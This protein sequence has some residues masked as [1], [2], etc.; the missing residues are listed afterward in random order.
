MIIFSVD[1]ELARRKAFSSRPIMRP[2][3][4]SATEA[5]LRSDLE[6]PRLPRWD[7]FIKVRINE[8][9]VPASKTNSN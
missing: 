4:A 7:S 5:G 1:T 2:V 6:K 3:A 9:W 8:I